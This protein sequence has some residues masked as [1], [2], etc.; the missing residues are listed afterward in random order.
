MM[1][2]MVSRRLKNHWPLPSLILVD[3]GV[4]QV[5]AAKE[6]VSENGVKI[7]VIGMVK[8]PDRK[9]TGLV[10]DYVKDADKKV[11]ERVRDEAHKFAISYHRAVRGRKMLE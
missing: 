5:N 6:A 10:G 4:S 7:P 8:G 11:L 2:E 3:G 1:K 9:G